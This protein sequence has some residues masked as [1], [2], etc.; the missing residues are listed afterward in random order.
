VHPVRRVYTCSRTDA[1]STPA[2]TAG[3][4]VRLRRILPALNGEAEF[5]DAV[6]TRAPVAQSRRARGRRAHYRLKIHAEGWRNTGRRWL[7]AR[8]CLRDHL[9]HITRDNA[10]LKGRHCRC[11][12]AGTAK[13]RT[14][15]PA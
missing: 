13:A 4:S 2:A 15:P 5:A 14:Q 10:A 9:I 7:L 1:E 12:P 6:A 8:R 11:S 3:T